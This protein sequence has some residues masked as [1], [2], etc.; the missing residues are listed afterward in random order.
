MTVPAL[1]V[2]LD[3]LLPDRVVADAWPRRSRGELDV[4]GS[5]DREPVDVPFAE[6]PPAGGVEKREELLARLEDEATPVVAVQHEVEPAVLALHALAERLRDLVDLFLRHPLERAGRRQ[7]S[8]V[9]RA[10]ASLSERIPVVEHRIVFGERVAVVE[11]EV[12]AGE[13]VREPARAVVIR[14]EGAR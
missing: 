10:T 11:P 3:E 14:R 5:R 13:R 7:A 4:H 1:L 2:G 8:G 9:D 6:T 12:I